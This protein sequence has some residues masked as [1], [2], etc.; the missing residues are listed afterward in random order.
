MDHNDFVFSKGGDGK[1]YGG[2]FCIDNILN[3][4]GGSPL[5]TLNN[6]QSGGGCDNIEHFSDIFKN[7]AVPSGL[8]SFPYKSG[9]SGSGSGSGS[10]NKDKDNDDE[11]V[12]DDLYN[13][14][15]DLV[16]EKNIK[17]GGKKTRKARIKINKSSNKRG[18]QKVN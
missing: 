10:R 13:K 3:K 2:G 5:I 17:S 12:N 9:G 15:L 1:I 7:Y 16:N 8:F 14:L 6:F 18:T 4:S 11:I